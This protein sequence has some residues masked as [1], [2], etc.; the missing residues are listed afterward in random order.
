M[1]FSEVGYIINSKRIQYSNAALCK[2]SVQIKTFLP[3]FANVSFLKHSIFELICT[4]FVGGMLMLHCV[5]IIHRHHLNEKCN[6]TQVH[7]K[8]AQFCGQ[9]LIMAGFENKALTGISR[10][11]N[12][13]NTHKR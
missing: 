10:K 8:V 7:K 3:C 4:I 9:I 13:L 6:G 12:H 1:K 5:H 2:I 11:Q